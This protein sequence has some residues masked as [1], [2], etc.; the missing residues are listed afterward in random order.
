MYGKQN[1]VMNIIKTTTF[2]TKARCTV[3]KKEKTI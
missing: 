1:R 2:E 3:C